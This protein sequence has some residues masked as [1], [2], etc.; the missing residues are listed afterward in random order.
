MYPLRVRRPVGARGLRR[1][2]RTRRGQ[3]RARPGRPRRRRRRRRCADLSGPR[4]HPARADP[5]GARPRDRLRRRRRDRQGRRRALHRPPA[6]QAGLARRQVRDPARPAPGRRR[7][8][9]IARVSG[10]APAA[11]TVAD[12]YA[13][14]GAVLDLQHD[15]AQTAIGMIDTAKGTLRDSLS[16][17][18]FPALDQRDTA[19]AYIHS[20]DI[21]AAPGRRRPPRPRQRRRRGR[22]LGDRDARRRRRDRRR[23]RSDRRRPRPLHHARQRRQR[24]APRRRAPSRQVPARRSPQFWPPVVGDD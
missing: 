5:E 3:G 23:D 24:R 22:R 19:I 17:T 16:R 7:R 9:L 8:R 10:G 11:G 12:Q 4:Q 15:V 13:T 20:I 21:P 6:G 1:R 2:R 14:T 18:I